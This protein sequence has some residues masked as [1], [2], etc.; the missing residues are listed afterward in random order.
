MGR[1]KTRIERT[2]TAAAKAAA[3]ARRPPPVRVLGVVSELADQPP[4]IAICASVL[5]VG[6]LSRNRRLANAGGRM[7]AAE[8]LATGMK[9]FVKHRIDRTRPHVEEDGGTYAMA[10]GDDPAPEANSFPSGHTAGAVAVA[11]AFAREYPEH[12]VAAYVTAGVMAAVQVPR[13][14]HYPTDL[15]AGAAVG[16]VGETMV[17]LAERAL[18]GAASHHR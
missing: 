17:H 4:L 3:P 12:A 7:L 2:D 14:K 13:C 6:L 16:A 8:L 9:S 1:E 18:A 5:A 15:A 11:R 10:P